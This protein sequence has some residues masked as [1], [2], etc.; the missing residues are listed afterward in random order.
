V[1]AREPARRS[2]LERGL[3]VAF[4]DLERE[5]GKLAQLD[6]ARPMALTDPERE[7]L[8]SL[9]RE[10]PR[11]WAAETT[12]DRD[13][14][15]LLRTLIGEVIVTADHEARRAAVEVQWQGGAQTELSFALKVPG[16]LQQGRVAEDTLEL[17]RRLAEHHCDR[18][19]AGI[20]SRQGRLT[21]TGLPFTQDRVRAIRSQTRR[22][23][24]RPTTRPQQR[25]AE[26]RARRRRAGRVG[27][28]HPPLDQHRVAPSRADHGRRGL[29]DPS[30]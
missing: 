21:G 15:E 16:K 3:E 24:G 14:K 5:R 9:A 19:I 30:D 25:G 1:R 22:H 10:L 18:E 26:H 7:T 2:T 12:T 13:R 28:H 20:L 23:P 6:R 27:A 29:A 8:V 17:I 11:L 4:V